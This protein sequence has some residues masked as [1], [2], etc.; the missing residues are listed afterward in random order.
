[1]DLFDTLYLSV[2]HHVKQYNPKR[3]ARWAR[4]YVSIFQIALCLLVGLFFI[5]F[6]K[7][8][9]LNVIDTTSLWIVSLGLIGFIFFKNWM[10]YN[11]RKRSILLS[12]NIKGSK[13]YSILILI[14]FQLAL[15]VLAFV[16]SKAT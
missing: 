4:I 5:K 13:P 2:F 14:V 16:L 12:K 11:G 1:M 8:M 15:F 6:A 10:S 3:A 7:Q 9:K